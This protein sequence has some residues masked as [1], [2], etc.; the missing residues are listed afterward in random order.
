MNLSFAGWVWLGSPEDLTNLSIYHPHVS[1]NNLIDRILAI[2]SYREIYRRHII[3]LLATTLAP[4]KLEKQI[5]EID[6]LIRPD[7]KPLPKRKGKDWNIKVPPL[8]E[9][10]RQRAKAIEAQLKGAEG[11]RPSIRF[12]RIFN[13]PANPDVQAASKVKPPTTKPAAK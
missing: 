13:L 1:D 5:D 8:R 7:G 9:F 6:K 4:D 10:P 11:Y 3:D 2:E 12:D